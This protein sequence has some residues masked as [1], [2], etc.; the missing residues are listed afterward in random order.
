[1]FSQFQRNVPPVTWQEMR[2]KNEKREELKKKSQKEV[3]SHSGPSYVNQF[4]RTEN[5]TCIILS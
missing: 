3:S 5:K 4:L 1:M 2:R